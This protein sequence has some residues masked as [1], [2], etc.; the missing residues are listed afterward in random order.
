MKSGANLAVG[1][2]LTA[3]LL[4]G[5][6]TAQETNAPEAPPASDQN[7]FVF[8]G[9]FQEQWVWETALFWRDH[10]EDNFFAG[11]GYQ[12]FLY[13]SDWGFKA[14]VELGA[15]LRMGSTASTEIWGGP[16]IRYDGLHIGDLNISPSV[17]AGLSLVTDTIGVET[18]RAA[19][20]GSSV[21]ILFYL[22]PEISFSLASNPNVEL[23][24]RIHHRSGGYG[25][26][27][28]IDG[29]NAATLGLRTK[30]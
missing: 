28:E 16:V 29:S 7:V 27:A 20:I 3:L 14:G 8:G 5:P 15:G 30:F 23:L 6:A 19:D 17:T 21:P 22:G 12:N 4:I 25:T 18:E 1:L 26:I 24:A 10:Y 13:H 2:A 11:V 9:T